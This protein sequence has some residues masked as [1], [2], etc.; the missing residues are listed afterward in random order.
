[1]HDYLGVDRTAPVSSS[2][3]KTASVDDAIV[4]IRNFLES[5]RQYVQRGWVLF[6]YTP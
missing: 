3:G 5:F 1:M 2:I 6:S 4:N